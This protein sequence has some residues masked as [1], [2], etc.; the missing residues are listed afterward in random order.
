M[1]LSVNAGDFADD[2]AYSGRRIYLN[3]AS[4]SLMPKS[5]IE[6][7]KE[8]LLTYNSVGPDSAGADELVTK[9][10]RSVRHII[11]GIISCQS[12]EVVLTQSTTDGINM[13][14]NGLVSLGAHSSVIVRG[15]EHEHHANLYPWLRLRERG[16]QIKSL[17]IGADGLF[18]IN[19]LESLLD[20][21]AGLVAVSHA[22]YNTGAIMPVEEM[23]TLI[24]RWPDCRFF[25]DSAQTI[26]CLSAVDCRV[27]TMQ[28]DYM[29]FNG[30]KWLCGPMGMGLFYCARDAGRLLKPTSVGGESA[31]I[32]RGVDEECG[33][34]G[35]VDDGSSN[36]TDDGLHLAFKELP[37]KLQTGF[38]N[39]AGVVGLEASLQYLKNVGFEKIRTI[40]KNLSAILVEE[41]E[42][43]PGAVVYAPEDPDMRTSIVSFNLDGMDPQ[44]LVDMLEKKGIIL[45]VREI[46]EHKV[47]RASPHFFN[48]ESQMH[49]L[50]DTLK[51]L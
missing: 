10:I 36:N 45:A 48:T 19:D 28:C 26:G 15:M 38:R 27:S 18:E 4:V 8:F 39:Y 46:A 43:L 6:A 42:R 25:V 2:F 47:V 33:S 30:S 40:N 21:D 7:I 29:S 3:N 20:D 12:D 37:D 1:S 16:V 14:A 5:S 17:P 24:G 13:V 34:G 32:C 9:K 49:A 31:M 11:S 41:L 44:Q 35:S 51:G 23:G 22:L 50:V